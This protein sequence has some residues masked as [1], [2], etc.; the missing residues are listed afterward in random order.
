MNASE[1]DALSEFAR[2]LM[3][4]TTEIGPSA[5]PSSKSENHKDAFSQEGQLA[6]ILEIE[7]RQETMSRNLTSTLSAAISALSRLESMIARIDGEIKDIQ[8]QEEERNRSLQ[9]EQEDLKLSAS[10]FVQL[11]AQK[12][13]S[14]IGQVDELLKNHSRQSQS[15]TIAGRINVSGND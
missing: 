6:L 8:E 4:R 7:K 12:L 11:T 1:K 9:R 10:T 14:V 13:D 3:E 2:R 5:G 15:K